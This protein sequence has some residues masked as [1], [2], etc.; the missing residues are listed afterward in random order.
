MHNIGT[1]CQG[2]NK[3]QNAL[4][5]A[6]AKASASTVVVASVPGAVVLPWVHEVAAV[7]TNFLPGQQGGNAIADVLFGA[8][9]PSGRLPLTFPNKENET[10]FS[11]AQWPGLPDPAHPTYANYSEK[12]LVGYRYYDAHGIEFSTG[13][14]FGH[15]LSYANFTYSNLQARALSQP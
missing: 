11:P 5:A 7:V 6:V 2:N 12:L 3:N 9:N 4:V 15:G 14:P 1:Q 10:E 8:V 13:F